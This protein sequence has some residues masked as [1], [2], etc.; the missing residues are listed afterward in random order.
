MLSPCEVAEVRQMLSA[1]KWSQRQIARQLG[2]SRATISAIANGKRRQK[3]P[4]LPVAPLLPFS[5]DPPVRCPLC[6][7]RV[8]LPCR[9]CYIRSLASPTS[10]PGAAKLARAG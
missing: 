10:S 7:G 2:I 5:T 9:L 6:G 1:G 4:A 3:L 8:Y